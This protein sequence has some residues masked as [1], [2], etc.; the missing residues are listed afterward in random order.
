MVLDRI[1]T[2]KFH[3]DKTIRYRTAAPK[4]GAQA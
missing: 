1:G 4:P 3:W 2:P